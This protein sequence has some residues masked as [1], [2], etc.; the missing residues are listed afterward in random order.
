MSNKKYGFHYEF[1]VSE[2]HTVVVLTKKEVETLSFAL[3]SL[4]TN[5][6]PLGSDFTADYGDLIFNIDGSSLKA[7]RSAYKK[8]CGSELLE[9]A[10]N[11]CIK[12]ND[13]DFI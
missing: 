1:S 7:V 6:E 4:F 3:T 13:L 12:I 10:N 9:D 2:N 8:I 5:L 11:E